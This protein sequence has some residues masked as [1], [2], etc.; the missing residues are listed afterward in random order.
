MTTAP[1]LTLDLLST[2]ALRR[3]G[4]RL[5]VPV[6]VERLLAYVALGNRRVSRAR[7]AGVLWPD[8]KPAR[9]TGCL[10]TAL[11]R[12]RQISDDVLLVTGTDL[13]LADGVRVDV[14]ESFA[15]IRRLQASGPALAPQSTPP[16]WLT[17]DLLPDWSDEWVVGR[18]ERWRMLRLDVLELLASRL[19]T[20]GRYSEAVDVSL[21]A[22]QDEPLRESAHRHLITAHLAAGNRAEAVLAYRRLS[23]LLDSELGIG[24]SPETAH[25]LAATVAT[26]PAKEKRSSVDRRLQHTARRSPLD[27]PA[28]HAA[29]VAHHL[30]DKWPVS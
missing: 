27:R 22:I 30:A 15:A 24:P 2:F 26:P 23:D 1:G 5:P 17:A 10:R 21:T 19:A 13:A 9:S 18:R 6:A 4:R 28:S 29:L 16:G 25:L 7:V 20:A 12:L 11:W 3:D 8:A 14:L